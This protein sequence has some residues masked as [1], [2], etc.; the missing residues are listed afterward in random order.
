MYQPG[1]GKALYCTDCKKNL[2][3]EYDVK[4]HIQRYGGY[5][6][7]TKPCECCGTGFTPKSHNA[8][9]C[10]DCSTEAKKRASKEWRKAYYQ[11]KKA[12]ISVGS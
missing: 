6:L 9:F 1:S 11:K 2:K 7:V 5:R 4:Q 3:K 8:R 10:S 12:L